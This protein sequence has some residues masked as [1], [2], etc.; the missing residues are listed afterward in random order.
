[1]IENILHII[2][3]TI[4]TTIVW[5]IVG[6]AVYMNPLTAKIY[7][8][9]EKHPSMK[10]WKTKTKYLTGVFFVA[11]LIPILLI[12]IAYQ[13]LT[14]INWLLFGLILFGI[15][16]IPRFCDMW[17]QTAYPNKILLIEIVNGLILSFV[18]AFMFSIL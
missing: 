10:K 11:G 15:R 6:G 14:P 2:Y 18:I 3:I 9:Y 13:Y 12:A 17:M 4:I 8:K 5:F 7:K 16:I 1:M